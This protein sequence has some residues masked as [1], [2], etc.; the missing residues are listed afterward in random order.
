MAVEIGSLV[1]RGTF[2]APGGKPGISPEEMEEQMAILRQSLLD[3]VR[4]MMQEA[5]RRARER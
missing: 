4:D 3:E 2:G 1:V 5:D